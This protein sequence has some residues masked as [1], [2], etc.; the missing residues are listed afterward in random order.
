M[1]TSTLTTAS[2]HRPPASSASTLPPAPPAAARADRLG[3]FVALS[4]PALFILLW[5]TGYVAGKIALPHAGPFTLL[6]LRFGLAAVVLLAV[7]AATGAPWPKTAR[8]WMHLGVVGLLMQVLHFSGVYCAIAWGL[9]T[10]VAALLIGMMPLATA[11][12]AHLWLAER[13]SV[14]QWLGMLGGAAG[15]ALVIVD[16][17]LGGGAWMAYGAGLLG[18]TGLVAGTLYQKRFCAG[19]DLRTG[20]GIQ[21][22]VSALAVL[23]LALWREPGAPDWSVELLGA[24]LWLGLVNSIGAF[25]LMFVMIRRGQAGAVAKLFYLIPGV[26]ALMGMGLLGEHFGAL[27]LAGFVVSAA[28]VG[29]ASMSRASG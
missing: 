21:M 7:S 26:S 28:S 23:A 13:M 10:G 12:G 9:P 1:T 29:L 14:A 20:S 19:M 27:A 3:A 5:S 24:T 18:L 8:A 2:L 15:V 11:M 4:L 6:A 16:R 17:P 22:T 25:S